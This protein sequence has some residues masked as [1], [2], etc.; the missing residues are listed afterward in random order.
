[1]ETKAYWRKRYL[2]AK[3]R[4][5]R[6][7]RAIALLEAKI[8]RGEAPSPEQ[9]IRRATAAAIRAVWSRP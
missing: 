7:E 3:A 4:K 8:A 5:R 9:A 2:A 1:M 6:A